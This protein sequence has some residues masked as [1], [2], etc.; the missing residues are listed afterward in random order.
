MVLVATLLEKLSDT[1]FSKQ[2]SNLC[3]LVIG[4]GIG[5]KQSSTAPSLEEQ[6]VGH[7]AQHKAKEDFILRLKN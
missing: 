2:H 6:L 3:E 5:V 4:A 7:A 1:L